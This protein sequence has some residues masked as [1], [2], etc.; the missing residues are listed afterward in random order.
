MNNAPANTATLAQVMENSVAIVML[1]MEGVPG[2]R[3]VPGTVTKAED[4]KE[5]TTL[6][7]PTL[8]VLPPEWSKQFAAVHLA[9]EKLI[10]GA[11][12]PKLEEGAATL[13]NGCYTIASARFPH[14]EAELSRIRE[15]QL[16][17]AIQA[18]MAAYD[19]IISK[20]RTDLG[21]AAWSKVAPRMPKAESLNRIS[22]QFV[23]LPITFLS[24][25]GRPFAEEVAKNII[26]GISETINQEAE[27]L[28][29]RASRSGNYQSGTFTNLKRQ[30]QILR[31]FSFLA[32]DETLDSLREAEKLFSSMGDD[33]KHALSTQAAVDNLNKIITDLGQDVAKDAGGRYRRKIIL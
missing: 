9:A 18:L 17:P 7:R 5:L 12:P 22:I 8:A 26:G 21:E 30:F 25:V 24:D 29:E 14:I 13:P 31:D 33:V 16:A 20:H 15:K 28:R 27:R 1:R 32:S 3:Q 2:H 11:A 6:S 23:R 19:G 4:G 10:K